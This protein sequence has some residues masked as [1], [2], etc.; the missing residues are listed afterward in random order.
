[1][2]PIGHKTS[3]ANF[4]RGKRHI[5]PYSLLKQ[6]PLPDQG[7]RNYIRELS[8]D[9]YKKLH[10]SSDTKDIGILSKILPELVKAFAIRLYHDTPTQSNHR[11]MHFIHKRYQ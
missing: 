1:M 11:I 2:N 3:V 10:R 4:K 7:T 8:I 9:I 6:D 5:K